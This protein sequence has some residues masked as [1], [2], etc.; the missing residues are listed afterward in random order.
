MSGWPRS[1]EALEAGAAVGGADAEEVGALV[2]GEGELA[3]DE[4]GQFLF[5]GLAHGFESEFTLGWFAGF[6]ALRGF[7]GGHVAPPFLQRTMRACAL[8]VR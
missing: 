8:I 3:A 2:H 7:V 4:V 1:G 5:G 6:L